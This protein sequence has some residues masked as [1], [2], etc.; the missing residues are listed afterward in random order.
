MN[1]EQISHP[2]RKG[3]G[4]VTNKP[5]RFERHDRVLT[6]DGWGVHE[7][8]VEDPPRK[9]R[10]TLGIDTAKT[11]IARNKSPDVPFDQSIN[12]YR[13]CEHGCVYCFARPTHAYY[14][15]VLRPRLRNTAVPQTGCGPRAAA[16][17][18]QSEIR[19]RNRLRSARTRIPYQP[20]ERAEGNH[21]PGAAGIWPN[22][23]TPSRSSPKAR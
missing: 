20:I 14:G 3:R 11:V 1:I 6:D 17:V 15:L 12:P 13:G 5:G 16:G 4:A 23:T 10:T 21:A 22:S 19:A 2:P 8:S 7:P 9:L 18:E